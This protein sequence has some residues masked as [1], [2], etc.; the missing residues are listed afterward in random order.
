MIR[1]DEVHLAG[2]DGTGR[3][4]AILDTGI[5]TSHPM[6]AGRIV[7]EAC[8]SLLASCPDATS[9]MVGVGAAV[10]CTGSGCGHG[11]SVAGVTAGRAA[12]DS[13]V[14][15]APAA[16]IIAI[17]VFSELGGG[18]IGAYTSDIVAGLQHVLGLSMTYAIDVANLSLGG[19]TYETVAACEASGSSTSA[20][21][22][23]LRDAGI[24]TV[25]AGG[26]D[27][28]VDALT[29]PACL[30]EVIGSARRPT[31]TSCRA[32]RT[33]WTC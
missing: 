1:A 15:V 7:E 32:T 23:R 9:A 27:G 22:G 5:D 4:V 33:P 2:D 3:T 10:P 8:F 12:D 31:P 29:S 13:L 24:V 18:D 11:T 28:L 25:A 16:N 20:A 17:Q 6:F 30:A 19:S 26:N 14:G 21:V